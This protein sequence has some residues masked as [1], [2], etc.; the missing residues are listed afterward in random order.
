MQLYYT[1]WLLPLKRELTLP[2]WKL[3]RVPRLLLGS[4]RPSDGTPLLTPLAM[5]HVLRMEMR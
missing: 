2:F 4:L 5:L 3:Q 1:R